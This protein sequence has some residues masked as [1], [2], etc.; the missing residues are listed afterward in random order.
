[1]V[2]NS[3]GPGEL[4]QNYGTDEQKNKYLPK[5]A[6]GEYI[7]CFGLTGPN[8][9]SDAIGTID[10]GTVI[11]ENNNIFIEIKINKRYITLAPISNLI[12]LAFDLKDPNNLLKKKYRYYCCFN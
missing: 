10:T 3:L 6:K 12:G 9:G 1:M 5:L 7:P 11:R 8:N 4:L 2:P